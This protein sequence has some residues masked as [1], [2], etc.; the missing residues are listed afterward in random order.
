MSEIYFTSDLH[1]MHNKGFLFEPRGFSNERDMCEALVENWN[2]IVK[3]DDVVYDLGDIALS[4]VQEAAKYIKKLNGKHFWIRGNH[5]TNNK[6]DYL[7][8]TCW[9]K[10]YFIGWAD[11]LKYN[12]YHFYISHYP[13][14]TANYDDKKFS[15]HV[16]NLH[17]HTHQQTNWLKLDN[18]FMY[19]VG[20]DS[21]NNA[22]V[23]ID[24][25]LTDIKNRYNQQEQLY[26]KYKEDKYGEIK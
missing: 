6:V 24:E 25:V 15:Q 11:M 5:D 3:P 13:T 19:H 9:D 7:M 16:I 18:P 20:V 21:H 26:D 12:K 22:P 2:K 14:L 23:H 4:D 17:G 1:M 10:L 8:D